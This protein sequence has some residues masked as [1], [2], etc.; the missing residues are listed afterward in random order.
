MYERVKRWKR[1]TLTLDID[2]KFWSIGGV[3]DLTSRPYILGVGLG[4]IAVA[5]DIYAKTNRTHKRNPLTDVG[6]GDWE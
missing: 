5:L 4:P 3:L 6:Y 1:F 2:W